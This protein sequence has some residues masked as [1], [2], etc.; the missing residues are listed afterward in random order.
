MV[1]WPNAVVVLLWTGLAT[2]GCCHLN[3]LPEMA[4]SVERVATVVE[5]GEEPTVHFTHQSLHT[6]RRPGHVYGHAAHR[7][8]EVLAACGPAGLSAHLVEQAPEVMADTLGWRAAAEDASPDATL[9]LI[10]ENYCFTALDAISELEIQWQVR[11]LLTA[12]AGD[13]LIWR[14]CLELSSGP[15]GVTMEELSRQEPE[16]HAWLLE[17]IARNL[18]RDLTAALARDRGVT[19]SSHPSEED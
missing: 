17:R 14:D 19:G 11:G 3:R 12:S 7:Y 5:V 2:P 6:F 10:I 8:D 15:L 9:V 16:Q 1:R 18:L 13:R 4:G